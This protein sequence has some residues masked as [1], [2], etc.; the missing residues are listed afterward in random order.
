MSASIC[1]TEIMR[2]S[3]RAL[4]DQRDSLPKPREIYEFLDSYVIGQ[5]KR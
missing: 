3:C 2:R 5:E 1:A 4:R